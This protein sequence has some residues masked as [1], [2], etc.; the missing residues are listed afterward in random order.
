MMGSFDTGNK[1]KE[2][3]SG[4]PLN[5][6]TLTTHTLGTIDLA[7]P[8]PED[9]DLDDI[10]AGLSKTCRWASQGR[11]YTVA[12]HSLECCWLARKEGYAQSVQIAC[13]MHDAHEAYTGDMAGGLKFL[14][15]DSLRVV[16]E[17]LDRAIEQRFGI[18][19]LTES[20]ESGLVKEIE[21]SLI[22]PEYEM[23][24][25]GKEAY[26]V[27]LSAPMHPEPAA[28]AFLKAA[29]SLGLMAGRM[30]G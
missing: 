23:L 13:L 2:G 30:S 20:Y 9:I 10:V 1:L 6:T 29:N 3:P 8:R 21:D 12:Q 24:F 25:L 11:W 28:V 4:E 22:Q 14:V 7:D 19:G 15:G 27:G 18:R 16:L 26:Q 17:A 5:K